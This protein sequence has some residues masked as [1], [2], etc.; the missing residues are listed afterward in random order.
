MDIWKRRSFPL[1]VK[2]FRFVRIKTCKAPCFV[3][4]NLSMRRELEKVFFC[5]AEIEICVCE[6]RECVFWGT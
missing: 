4:P 1:G 6:E 2:N 3:H 5:D